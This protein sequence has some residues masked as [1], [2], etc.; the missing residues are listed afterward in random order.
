MLTHSCPTC[1]TS[2]TRVPRSGLQRFFYR[3]LLACPT[4][5]YRRTE[6]RVP[7]GALFS[8]LFS[9]HTHCLRCGNPRVRRLPSRD[10]IDRMSRHPFSLLMGLT[11]API[12]H[13]GPC[14]LQ[15][16]DWRRPDPTAGPHHLF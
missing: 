1:Q 9:R 7:G 4:C 10:H 16:R 11:R 6:L 14:R 2:L 13:C 12:Q 8:F 5:T 15:Y 3:R